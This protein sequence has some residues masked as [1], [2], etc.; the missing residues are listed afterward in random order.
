VSTE[1][2]KSSR[3]FYSMSPA[4]KTLAP[5]HD[6]HST[7]HAPLLAPLVAKKGGDPRYVLGALTGSP[8]LWFHGVMV[9]DGDVEEMAADSTLAKKKP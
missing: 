8:K 4:K 1:E 6:R 2:E 9:V 5:F 3:R 7:C